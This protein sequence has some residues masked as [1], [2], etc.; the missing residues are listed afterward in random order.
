[1]GPEHTP[2]S[3]RRYPIPVPS[4][5]REQAG[6]REPHSQCPCFIPA[7]LGPAVPAPPPN[8]PR[9]PGVH[10]AELPVRLRARRHPAPSA[11]HGTAQP[12]LTCSAAA[13][14]SRELG[15]SGRPRRVL[16]NFEFGT[17]SEAA[18]RSP[19]VPAKRP[20]GSQSEARRAEPA[21]FLFS[22]LGRRGERR[23]VG[24][25]R[26]RARSAEVWPGASPARPRSPLGPGSAGAA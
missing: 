13:A 7:Q 6:L 1:M 25:W 2:V 19:P 11:P 14:A 17:K 20:T 23:V 12:A 26:A 18:N 24:R 9:C 22:L 8:S 10:T 16:L 3:I 21:P 5:G 15:M 4:V